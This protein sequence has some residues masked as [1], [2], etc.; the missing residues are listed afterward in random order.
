MAD[1]GRRTY[2]L[3][4][5]ACFGGWVWKD[6]ATRLRA[7][8]HDVYTP[9]LT[10]LG[11]RQHL[12]RAGITLDTH[13]QDVALLIHMENLTDVVLVGWSY[14]GM[15]V[16]DVLG[17]IPGRIGSMIFLDAMLPEVGRSHSSYA[18]PHPVDKIVDLAASGQDI[19]PMAAKDIGIDDPALADHIDARL[20]AHPALTF[21]SPSRIPS[22]LPEM[23][24]T[25][26]LS[27]GHLHNFNTF[28]P[29]YE[30]FRAESL[31]PAHVIA[32]GHTMMLTEPQATTDFLLGAG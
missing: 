31:G 29:F 5:G 21:L 8:G 18:A 7:A 28:L 24:Y 10:G 12:L 13:A 22:Q 15:V 25:Y 14:G 19:P 32:T 17:L 26:V 20:S 27:G 2:V 16:S 11:D 23:P 9:S 1:E 30:R 4:H 6:V 3:V